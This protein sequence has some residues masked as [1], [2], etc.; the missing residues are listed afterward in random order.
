MSRPYLNNEEREAL[1]FLDPV[2]TSKFILAVV[3]AKN[4]AQYEKLLASTI[5]EIVLEEKLPELSEE[6]A[7]VIKEVFE[8]A[9]SIIL[10]MQQNTRGNQIEKLAFPRQENPAMRPILTTTNF[11]KFLN[12]YNQEVAGALENL[13]RGV[14]DFDFCQKMVIDCLENAME[15]AEEISKESEIQPSVILQPSPQKLS[16]TDNLKKSM[17]GEEKSKGVTTLP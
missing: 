1:L 16:I 3:E 15:Q 14:Q 4:E 10:P 8:S 9:L 13:S 5:N 17:S 6:K 11:K 12:I 2:K 7:K